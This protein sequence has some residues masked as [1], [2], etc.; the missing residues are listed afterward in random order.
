[1]GAPGPAR[2]RFRPGQRSLAAQVADVE[3]VSCG[4]LCGLVRSFNP[5]KPEREEDERR[6]RRRGA[7]PGEWGLAVRFAR[8][9]P[10][11]SRPGKSCGRRHCFALC[12]C[13]RVK[14]RIILEAR[15]RTDGP[16]PVQPW[17]R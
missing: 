10:E 1:M 14:G 13:R 16:G 5:G 7:G 3:T 17:V 2:F 4:S 9:V 12:P 8:A 6:G 11:L 15:T